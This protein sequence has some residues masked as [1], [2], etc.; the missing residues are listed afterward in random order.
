MSACV[1]CASRDGSIQFFNVTRHGSYID[2]TGLS[3]TH[4]EKQT[5]MK[6]TP[7]G[8]IHLSTDSSEK[9]EGEGEGEGGTKSFDQW[10]EIYLLL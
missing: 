7:I 10:V 3:A 4:R 1:D 6:D 5:G 8:I 9:L 2:L